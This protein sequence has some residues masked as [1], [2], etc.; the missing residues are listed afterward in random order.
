MVSP[1]RQR[2]LARSSQPPP[3]RRVHA[4]LRQL[5]QG[6]DDDG[7]RLAVVLRGDPPVVGVVPARRPVAAAGLL[8]HGDRVGDLRLGGVRE[9]EREGHQSLPA[10]RRAEPSP[11]PLL[12]IDVADRVRPRADPVRDVLVR[13]LR[14][15]PAPLPVPAQF[16]HQVVGVLGAA[17]DLQEHHRHPGLRGPH[18]Q[19]RPLHVAAAE[20]VADLGLEAELVADPGAVEFGGCR[21]DRGGV[22][23]VTGAEQLPGD[24]VVL[25]LAQHRDAY[26]LRLQQLL[27]LAMSSLRQHPHLPLVLPDRF[28]PHQVVLLQIQEVVPCELVVLVVGAGQLP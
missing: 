25:L 23:V 8:Q 27:R 1:S 12:V 6:G 20:P 21:G 15:Q 17:V 11:Q 16:L 4:V 7:H 2:L 19:V 26:A 14:E 5:L 22:V 3:H 24:R 13:V 9:H 28:D 18:H 10:G